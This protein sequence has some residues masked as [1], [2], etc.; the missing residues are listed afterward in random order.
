M[1]I[2][3]YYIFVVP[4]HGILGGLSAVIITTYI[5][6]WSTRDSRVSVYA[7]LVD[8][9]R[10]IGLGR[11]K[12]RTLRNCLC[13]YGLL[14]FIS[15]A[16]F[17]QDNSV[18]VSQHVACQ[19]IPKYVYQTIRS[20]TVNGSKPAH[21]AMF[22][23][24]CYDYRTDEL[25][26]IGTTFY[27]TQRTSFLALDRPFQRPQVFRVSSMIPRIPAQCFDLIYI[28]DA[29]ILWRR[30]SFASWLTKSISSRAVCNQTPVHVIFQYPEGS[31]AK[32]A[33]EKYLLLEKYGL[34]CCWRHP[35]QDSYSTEP[36]RTLPS[37][38]NVLL[39][40]TLN[41]YLLPSSS[42]KSTATPGIPV[43]AL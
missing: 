11:I 31:E 29:S 38:N 22:G 1:H 34:S 13:L 42:S 26:A 24:P 5:L 30:R 15:T 19:S 17:F 32:I 3:I 25:N 21:V 7:M 18:E 37:P 39:S 28:A 20:I 33:D 8:V 6:R 16:V 2:I 10:M 12:L 14:F 40:R 41:H 4:F 43:D 35:W 36:G 23:L 9:K 27:W